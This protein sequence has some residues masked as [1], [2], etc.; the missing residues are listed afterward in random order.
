MLLQIL[1]PLPKSNRWLRKEPSLGITEPVKTLAGYGHGQVTRDAPTNEVVVTHANADMDQ[2][3][4]VVRSGVTAHG[5]GQGLKV[6]SRVEP[7]KPHVQVQ[8]NREIEAE[9]ESANLG[10]DHV[11]DNFSDYIHRAKM[12]IRATTDVGREK[13]VTRLDSFS[14]KV[15][16]YISRAKIK[17]RSPT[18]K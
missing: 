3:Q 8:G 1:I 17:L 7:E 18:F 4:A 2:L 12:K 15:S 5:H 9:D 6:T 13:N 16:N 11:E 14:D 10:T